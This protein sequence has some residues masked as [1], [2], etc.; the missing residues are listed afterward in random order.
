MN[1]LKEAPVAHR[2]SLKPY[3]CSTKKAI[4]NSIDAIADEIA[5]LC[6]EKYDDIIEI[7]DND[8]E[9]LYFTMVQRPYDE[10]LD[11]FIDTIYSIGSW[12]TK[13]YGEAELK[14]SV[15][16]QGINEYHYNGTI[17]ILYL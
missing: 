14:I 1:K 13:K 3:T 9:F 10:E 4:A 8:D 16:E 5:E 6:M 15:L 11:E 12:I 2:E 17:K 7:Y